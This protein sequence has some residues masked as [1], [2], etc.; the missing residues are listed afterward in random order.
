M[1][2]RWKVQIVLESLNNDSVTWTLSD[3]ELEELRADIKAGDLGRAHIGRVQ[4][5]SQVGLVALAA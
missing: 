4:P 2:N 1:V 5:L 3:Q